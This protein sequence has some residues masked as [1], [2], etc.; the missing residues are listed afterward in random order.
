M[1]NAIPEHS[2]Q[3]SVLTRSERDRLL[4]KFRA[5]DAWVEEALM[6]TPEPPEED[7]D[8][9]EARQVV[10]KHEYFARLPQVTLSRCPI[11]ATA[12]VFPFDAWGLEGF[13]W[14]ERL[15]IKLGPSKACEHFRLL[16]G[17]VHLNG[18]PP[19]GGQAPSHI[20]PE[21]PYVVPRILGMSTMVAVV[22]SVPM[23][24]GYTAYPIAY[25][26]QNAP[27]IGSLGAPWT[28]TTYGFTTPDG[29]PGWMIRNDAWDF[30]VQKWVGGGK[31]K[32]IEPDDSQFH[33]SQKPSC[34]Y[35]DV[36]G[37]REQLIIMGNEL[38]TVPTPDP[39]APVNPFTD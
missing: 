27:P 28:R 22:S 7:V 23:E 19:K 38:S 31:L 13:W 6:E 16:L 10:I 37:R 25:F 12:L 11:C 15:S 14:Q 30:D 32:W 8:A 17:A 4:A 1:N 5:E 36:K 3:P 21:V 33:I 39:D 18:L 20:G 26:S 34:P 29:R 9:S 24:N 35:A 2:T